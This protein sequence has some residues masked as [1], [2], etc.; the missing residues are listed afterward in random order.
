MLHKKFKVGNDLEMVQSERNYPHQNRG[1]KGRIDNQVLI[2]TLHIINRVSSYILTGGHSVIEPI[3]L[4]L[5]LCSPLKKPRNP[6]LAC[7]L[8]R[9]QTKKRFD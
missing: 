6:T 5:P 7:P 9:R 8:M 3:L 2:Q 1:G 4:F